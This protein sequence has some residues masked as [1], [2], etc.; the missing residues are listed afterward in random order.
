M[1]IN[2]VYK[3]ELKMMSRTIQLPVLV[4]IFNAV[5]AVVALIM[6][7]C[8]G[9]SSLSDGSAP[10]EYML[11]FYTLILSIEV[12]LLCLFVPSAAGGSIAGE[13]ERQTLDIL[14]TSRMTIPG[15]II[16]KL[17]SC[18]SMAV[19][20]VTSSLPVLAIVL[21]YG[22]IHL[23]DIYQSVVYV[24]F[25][26][27]F[28]GCI[29][30][31][32]SCAFKKTTTASVAAYG[33]LAFLTAGTAFLVALLYFAFEIGSNGDAAESVGWLIYFWLLNPA[34]T[35]VAILMQQYDG[36]WQ[37]QAF[38]RQ[39]GASEFAA[40]YWIVLSLA[41][42]IIFIIIL[43]IFSGKYLSP[44]NERFQVGKKSLKK[45]KRH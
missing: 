6:L 4:V 30:I 23:T 10:Y 21:M 43:L 40:D 26:I 37:I 9:R 42:Q 33:I 39:M 25:L 18:I 32:C 14:L 16:G 5:L 31:F 1:R 35:Y 22:G 8:I 19:L 15:I 36:G 27:L 29:G 2:P 12:C 45:H 34:V 3:K 41:V 20:L 7:Y 11:T 24:I 13:R 38:I 28:I 44:V 17:F